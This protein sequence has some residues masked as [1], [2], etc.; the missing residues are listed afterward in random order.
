MLLCDMILQADSHDVSLVKNIIVIESDF[1]LPSDFSVRVFLF[2]AELVRIERGELG[3]NVTP[4]NRQ[5]GETHKNENA[6]VQNIIMR[7]IEIYC[8]FK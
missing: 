4:R 1:S 8:T 6:L 5:Y 2:T 3:R 7:I